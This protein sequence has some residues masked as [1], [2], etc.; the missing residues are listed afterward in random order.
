LQIVKKGR[1]KLRPWIPEIVSKML[2]ALADMEPEAVNYLIMNADKYNTTG[3]H[4]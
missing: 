4:V 3:D 2:V 1:S